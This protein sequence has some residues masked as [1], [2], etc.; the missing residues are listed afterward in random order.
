MREAVSEALCG[1]GYRIVAAANPEHAI[2]YLQGG[3]R[4]DLVVSDVKMPGKLTVTDLIAHMKAHQPGIPI[5]FATGYSADIAVQEGLIEGQYPVLFKPFS[6]VELASKVRAL[7]PA[8][9]A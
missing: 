2:L 7:L 8:Q 9:L 4:V 6:R 5:L 3:L 1:L